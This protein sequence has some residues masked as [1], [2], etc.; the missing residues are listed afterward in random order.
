[1]RNINYNLDL[2]T[3]T[4]LNYI[5]NMSLEFS[6]WIQYNG[7]E[8]DNDNIYFLFKSSQNSLS[9][10]VYGGKNINDIYLLL[11]G[12]TNLIFNHFEN[13]KNQI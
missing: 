11:K 3:P 1:M 12:K 9:F 4:F 7:V 8:L 13:L 2:V 10:K 5:K 6:Q